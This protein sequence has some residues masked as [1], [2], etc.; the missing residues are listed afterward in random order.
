VYVFLLFI[1][2]HDTPLERL[3]RRSS[4]PTDAP[5]DAAMLDTPRV[6]WLM[7]CLSHEDAAVTFLAEEAHT[8]DEMQRSRWRATDFC[9]RAVSHLMLVVTSAAAASARQSLPVSPAPREESAE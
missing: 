8:R 7:I 3:L 5:D 4:C 9:R 2:L 1:L 6:R